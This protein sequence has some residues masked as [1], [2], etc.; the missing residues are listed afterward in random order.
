[1]RSNPVPERLAR[2]PRGQ[3]RSAGMVWMAIVE[4]MPPGKGP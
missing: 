2:L 3:I 4:L 1:M